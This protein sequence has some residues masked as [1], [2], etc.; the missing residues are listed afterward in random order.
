M[1]YHKQIHTEKSKFSSKK[2]IYYLS[3]FG[4]LYP[5]KKLSSDGIS[6]AIIK[7]FDNRVS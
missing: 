1:R 2:S 5:E 7:P 4:Y 3:P 6:F